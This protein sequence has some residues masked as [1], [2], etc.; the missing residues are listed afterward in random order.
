MHAG[1]A[2]HWPPRPQAVARAVNHGGSRPM[3]VQCPAA[4]ILRGST[5]YVVVVHC[6]DGRRWAVAKRFSHFDN[7]RKLISPVLA[8]LAPGTDQLPFPPKT[9]FR[10]G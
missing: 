4:R 8:R 5:H 6:E 7:F 9:P 3:G 2:G 1:G 10:S